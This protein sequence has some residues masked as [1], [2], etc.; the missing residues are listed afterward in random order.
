MLKVCIICT[1]KTHVISTLIFLKK[2]IFLQDIIHLLP[3]VYSRAVGE[4]IYKPHGPTKTV[5][6]IDPHKALFSTE[7]LQWNFSYSFTTILCCGYSLE[8]LHWGTESDGYP[9]H[10]VFCG[11]IR[12][13][14]SGYPLLSIDTSGITH[15]TCLGVL[16]LKTPNTTIVVCFVFCRIL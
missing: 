11:K 14:V 5:F 3:D 10:N 9:Q 1:M 15:R 4:K 8:A 12:K 6:S 16:T 2:I 7:K 13:I